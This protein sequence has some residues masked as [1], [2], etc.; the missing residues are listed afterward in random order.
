MICSMSQ[1]GKRAAV[2]PIAKVESN[3]ALYWAIEHHGQEEG[4]TEVLYLFAEEGEEIFHLL[5]VVESRQ[6]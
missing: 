2:F 4:P 6:G 5:A 1:H 3:P